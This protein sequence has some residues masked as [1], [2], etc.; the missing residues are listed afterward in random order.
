MI[1]ALVDY[2]KCTSPGTIYRNSR[3]YVY[4]YHVFSEHKITLLFDDE[5]QSNIPGSSFRQVLLWTPSQEICPFV[6]I[7]R[8]MVSAG[9]VP[10]EK[11]CT[12]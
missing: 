5:D 10:R 6:D 3:N 8:Q 9:P 1:I 4:Y 2:Y 7:G 11:A 12:Y